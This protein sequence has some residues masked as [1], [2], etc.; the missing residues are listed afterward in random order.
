MR[1]SRG[2]SRWSVLALA[3]SMGALLAAGG[4]GEAGAQPKPTPQTKPEGEM[5][6]AL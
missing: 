3:V 1:R 5:R 4:L 6:W 2:I